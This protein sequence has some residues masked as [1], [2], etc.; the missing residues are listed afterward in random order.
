TDVVMVLDS[1]GNS[2]TVSI[3]VAKITVTPQTV[4]LPPF[5][6]AK[7]VAAGGTITNFTWSIDT[8]RSGGQID[9]VTGAY[10]AGP[11]DGVT[12]VVKVVDSAG[13]SATA[14]AAVANLAVNP[15]LA[16]V[17]PRGTLT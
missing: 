15:P 6:T 12:D 4:S 11:V 5:G 16:S 14:T 2:A 13:N 7:F 3:A 8:N 9:P 10:T 17:V 1:L